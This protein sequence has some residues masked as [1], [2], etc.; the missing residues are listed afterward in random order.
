MN[1]TTALVFAIVLFAQIVSCDYNVV[2]K[3]ECSY[4]LKK[5]NRNA[6]RFQDKLDE[7]KACLLPSVENKI[8]C[9]SD[10]NIPASYMKRILDLSLKSDNLTTENV[11]VL[12]GYECSELNWDAENRKYAKDIPLKEYNV[13]TES[14]LI[15][16]LL[17]SISI[18]IKVETNKSAVLKKIIKLANLMS[19]NFGTIK[20]CLGEDII[21][22]KTEFQQCI[23]ESHI[24]PDN[25][26]ASA[27]SALPEDVTSLGGP[28]A[29]DD[30]DLKMELNKYLNWMVTR[31]SGED[32]P[33]DMIWG[34]HNSNLSDEQVDKL[35]NNQSGKWFWFKVGGGVLAV[36]V[37]VGLLR[38]KDSTS[39]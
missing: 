1:Y 32:Y 26:L 10:T 39:L 21:I 3:T 17:N 15:E 16:A 36:A 38:N 5:F 6:R 28:Q 24:D 18:G 8:P 7:V 25:E 23:S 30:N 11:N 34:I 35:I 22:N 37:L 13:L 2:C 4:V 31:Y 33:S 20:S 29:V 14:D 12:H 9:L 19:N 27:L